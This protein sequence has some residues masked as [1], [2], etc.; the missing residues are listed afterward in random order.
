MG[1]FSNEISLNVSHK[2]RKTVD[3]WFDLPVGTG[4]LRHTKRRDS[5]GVQTRF[6]SLTYF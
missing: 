1:N 2:T 5:V 6:P 3:Y 4:S